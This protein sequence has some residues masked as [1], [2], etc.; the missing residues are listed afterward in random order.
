MDKIGRSNG[1][2][3]MASESQASLR[4]ALVTGGS[5]GIGAA[6]VRALGRDG[7]RVAIH[8]RSCPEEA[9][10]L[11]S[12]VSGSET[13]CYDLSSEDACQSL[14]KEVRDTLGPVD[15][16]VNNAGMSVDQILPFAKPEDFEKL[17]RTNLKPVFLLSKLCSRMMIRK[18]SGSIINITSIVGH[19]GNSGQSMYAAT[20]SAVTGMTKSAA[21]DLAGHG[22]RANCVAPG[23]VETAMTEALPQGVKE[24]ILAKIPMKRMCTPEEVAEAVSFLAS[25]QSS[26]I[27]G[28]TLHVNGGMFTS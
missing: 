6:C 22:V 24:Q 27:T 15:V 4:V 8:Y 23:F 5:K 10:A 3:S 20:K 21:L 2:K 9:Q 12:E 26:Y 25:N 7:F 1:S 28:S 19:T 16:L 17:L 18:K 13:F 14:I 11:Q